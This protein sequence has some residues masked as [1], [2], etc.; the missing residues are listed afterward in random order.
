MDKL[1]ILPLAS[2][3]GLLSTQALAQLTTIGP[4]T[5]GVTEFTVSMVLNENCSNGP[6]FLPRFTPIQPLQPGGG[7]IDTGFVAAFNNGC[8]SGCDLEFA[9]V[10]FSMFDVSFHA[11]EPVTSVVAL[12][13][14]FVPGPD[15]GSIGFSEMLAFD[16]QQIVAE[17][18]AVLPVEA[19]ETPC[20]RNTQVVGTNPFGND[21]VGNLTVSAPN[22]TSVWI[23][24]GYAATP[25][26]AKGVQF[27]VPEP[28][29]FAL[30]A[31][32]L[33]GLAVTRRRLVS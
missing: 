29:T 21:L 15:L 14:P 7:G 5:P 10:G 32:A 30:L 27:A 16:G 17:C 6:C 25:A 3:C 9:P 13:M 24:A 22:I 20:Y 26:F 8:F 4:N 18:I 2:I 33:V 11:A 31:F 12:R 23:G 1:R 19:G 28:D